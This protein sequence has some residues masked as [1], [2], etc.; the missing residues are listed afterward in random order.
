MLRPE[1]TQKLTTR[2]ERSDR[3]EVRLLLKERTILIHVRQNINGLTSLYLSCCQVVLLC[4]FVTWRDV[5]GRP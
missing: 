5:T 1:K 3:A 2:F 4:Y